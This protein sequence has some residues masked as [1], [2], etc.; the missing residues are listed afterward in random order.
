MK[1]AIL[2]S[3][4]SGLQM[5]KKLLSTSY[6][7]PS[8]KSAF[9][10]VE[11]PPSLKFRR[12]S[13]VHN[14]NVKQG[15]TIVELLVVIVVIG[16]L[17]AITIV[18]YTGISGKAI[19]SSVKSDI[20]QAY[21]QLEIS[22]TTS[23]TDVYPVDQA[24]A[25]LKSSNGTTYTYY[26]DSPYKSYC[27]VATNNSTVYSVSSSNPLPISGNCLSNGLVGYW[28]LDNTTGTTDL[29][30]NGNNGTAYG[31]M[32]IGTAANHLGTANKATTFDGVDDYVDVQHNI[33]QINLPLTISTWV[34]STIVNQ[35]DW[36]AFISKYTAGSN[37]GWGI[38]SSSGEYHFYYFK[39]A[40]NKLMS[41]SFGY[42][43][44]AT[45]T[46]WVL[47]TTVVN[48]SGLTLYRN[49]VGVTSGLWTG[50]A[51]NSSQSANLQIGR[52]TN[53]GIY[54]NGLISDVRIYN[55]ALTQTEITNLYNSN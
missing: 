52:I 30:G 34:K 2:N 50:I 37:N 14:K 39:D 16:I 15:F 10:I 51:G 4:F 32:S 49:G 47:L 5:R 12:A 40:S 29:S 1:S 33:N 35:G 28:A 38:D 3:L 25:N 21:K 24:S 17:A 55:R 46:D 26:S 36:K 19:V 20:S 45:S 48:T 11:L 6:K 8:T 23:S 54:F 43:F 27:L 22:K 41:G 44:G 9:T 7:I 42:S 13:L 18:S 31:T 53:Y